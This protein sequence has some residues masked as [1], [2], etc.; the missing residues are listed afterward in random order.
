MRPLK[1]LLRSAV[2]WL[3]VAALVFHVAWL[4]VHLLTTAHCDAGPAHAH[5][6]AHTD[7]HGHDHDDADHHHHF[8]GDHE[9]KFLSKR[10]AVLFAPVLAA[11]LTTELDVPLM[12]TARTL[13][14][15]EAAPPPADFSPP[16]GPRAPPLA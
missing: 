8:T 14:R 10:H 3:A 6:H 16:A 7:H 4:P 12:A 5:A 15:A 2:R 9:S 13:P 1:H 11:W